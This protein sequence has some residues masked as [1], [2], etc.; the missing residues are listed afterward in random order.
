MRN[1]LVS[2]VPFRCYFKQGAGFGLCNY[3]GTHSVTGP[4]VFLDPVVSASMESK[5]REKGQLLARCGSLF[6][7]IFIYFFSSHQRLCATSPAPGRRWRVGSDVR[8]PVQSGLA[9]PRQSRR[10]QP[11]SGW[12]AQSPGIWKCVVRRSYGIPGSPRNCGRFG[13]A[14]PDLHSILFADGAN[15]AIVT[16]VLPL[17]AQ[18]PS[19]PMGHTNVD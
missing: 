14:S 4:G 11:Y 13:V 2:W 12:S 9:R 17:C 6:L 15:L 10:K 8:K 5:L 16:H 1:L 18:F 3:A 7:F 19:G